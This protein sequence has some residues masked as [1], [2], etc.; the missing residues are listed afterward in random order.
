MAVYVQRGERGGGGGE[1]SILTFNSAFGETYGIAANFV[2]CSVNAK[3][4]RRNVRRI[5]N[6]TEQKVRL[7]R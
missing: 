1:S 7:Y 2:A 3:D 4:I 6:Y 5:V